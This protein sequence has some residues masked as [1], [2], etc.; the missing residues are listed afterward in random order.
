MPGPDI[1]LPKNSRAA[2]FLLKC[3]I[4]AVATVAVLAQPFSAQRP[5]IPALLQ[6]S[7][8]SKPAASPSQQQQPLPQPQPQKDDGTYVIRKN[9][10][11]VMLHA[12]VI[13]SK[14]RMVTDLDRNAFTVLEDG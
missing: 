11:E 4:R 9:V 1:T 10:D 12:T 14:Q 2:I 5:P 13:D 3:V 8:P 6:Q 7:V